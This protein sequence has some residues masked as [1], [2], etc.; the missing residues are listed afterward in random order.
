[1]NPILQPSRSS[2]SVVEN[3]E[4]VVQCSWFQQW[5][6]V[7]EVSFFI[8]GPMGSLRITFAEFFNNEWTCADSWTEDK[9]SFCVDGRIESTWANLDEMPNVAGANSSIGAC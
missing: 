2:S 5:V 9:V 7:Y 4:T 3:Y 8:S 6:W 1:M